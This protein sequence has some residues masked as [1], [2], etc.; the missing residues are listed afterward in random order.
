[1]GGLK[2]VVHACA[3]ALSLWSVTV[4][5]MRPH[6]VRCTLHSWLGLATVPCRLELGEFAHGIRKFLDLLQVSA[7]LRLAWLG[8]AQC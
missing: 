8:L 5:G 6:G 7:S 4:L 1:M 3:A 2:A